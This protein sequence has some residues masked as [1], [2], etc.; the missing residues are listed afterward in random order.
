MITTDYRPGSPCWIEL[1]ASDLDRSLAFYRGL[2][3]WEAESAGPDTGGYLLLKSGGRTVGGAGPLMEEEQRPSWTLY[4]QAPDAEEYVRGVAELGGTVDLPPMD[5]MGM[6]VMAQCTDPQGVR[7]ALWQPLSFPGMETVDEPG[8]LVWAE[9]WTP[10]AEGARRFY[11][12]LFPW[13]FGPFELPGGGTYLT[14]RPEGLDEDRA[15]SGI[16]Q[17]DPGTAES[18]GGG[19]WHPVFQVEDV[20]ATAALVPET[21]GRV[22]MAPDDA[23]GVGRL[24]A[25]ADPDGN[26]FVLL[27]PSPA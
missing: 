11:G 10:D 20:D 14:V 3:G 18:V 24:S 25:C 13:E 6:G 9:L 12:G 8:T 5:V 7:F 2:F 17:V 26:P 1:S 22:D 4:F 27:R 19:D 23:P 15:H 21:G 16:A